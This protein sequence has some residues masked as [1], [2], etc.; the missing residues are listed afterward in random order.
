M[1]GAISEKSKSSRV[2]SNVTTDMAPDEYGTMKR[3]SAGQDGRLG[4][5]LGTRAGLGVRSLGSKI[6]RHHVSVLA[7][8]VVEDFEDT[9]GVGR[10]N[11]WKKED[12]QIGVGVSL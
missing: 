3:V 10:Q 4:L 8:L 2:G 12:V 9:P 5:R 6:Q 7:D 1:E 11:A